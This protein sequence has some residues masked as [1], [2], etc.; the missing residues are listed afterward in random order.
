MTVSPV[1]AHRNRPLADVSFG[2]VIAGIAVLK[3][4]VDGLIGG[5][6][7]REHRDDGRASYRH[8]LRIGKP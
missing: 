7:W 3:L 8:Q 4:A 1:V 5:R 2:E 6:G